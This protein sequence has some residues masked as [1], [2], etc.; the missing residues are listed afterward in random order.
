MTAQMVR[1][2]PIEIYLRSLGATLWGRSFE[3]NSQEGYERAY[4]FIENLWSELEDIYHQI[5]G[6]DD[7][8]SHLD[9]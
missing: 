2:D 9:V 7:V 5:G 4:Q 1:M 8:E 3:I 6:Y